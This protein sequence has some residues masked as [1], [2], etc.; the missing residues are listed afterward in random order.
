MPEKKRKPT[1]IEMFEKE[2]GDLKSSINNIIELLEKLFE[3]DKILG[4]EVGILMDGLRDVVKMLKVHK[5]NEATLMAFQII[6]ASLNI[7]KEFKEV[8]KY[9]RERGKSVKEAFEEMATKDILPEGLRYFAKTKK[10]IKEM[11]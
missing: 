6:S 4:E 11:L 9:A 5:D 2:I 10:L 7:D 8:R 1:Y 3:H